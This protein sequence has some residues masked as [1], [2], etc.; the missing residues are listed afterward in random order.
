MTMR[1]QT[2]KKFAGAILNVLLIHGSVHFTSKFSTKQLLSTMFYLKLTGR[3]L[4]IVIFVKITQNQLFI[5]F[6]NVNMLF[7]FGMS[8]SKL[9]MINMTL[10]SPSQT[11]MKF[12]AFMKI[13][14][15]HI[16]FYVLNIT[17]I[18]VNSRI[19][20]PTLLALKSLLKLTGKLNT[21]LLRKEISFQL[22]TKN[23]DSICN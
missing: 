16:Y 2:G 13:T 14:F 8:F 20:N 7:Q 5:F 21:V 3:I 1:T 22:T 18:F 6:V 11:L 17:F 4:L 23:G 10:I 9:F 19:R 15:S 12:L